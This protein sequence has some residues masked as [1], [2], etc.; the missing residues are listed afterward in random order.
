[1]F[2]SF[3]RSPE[4]AAAE[5]AATDVPPE[6]KTK[7]RVS[8]QALQAFLADKISADKAPDIGL[9]MIK[10]LTLLADMISA[11]KGPDIQGDERDLLGFCYAADW[12]W[13]GWHKGDLRFARDCCESVARIARSDP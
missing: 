7:K 5:K 1:M 4:K 3:P 9:S 2:G 11:D 12:Q 13:P 8:L 6:E 10:L